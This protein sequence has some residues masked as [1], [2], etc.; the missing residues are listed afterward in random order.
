MKTPPAPPYLLPPEDAVTTEDWR[1]NDGSQIPER[2]EHWDPFTDIDLVRVVNVNIDAV[3]KACQLGDDS[4]LAVTASWVSTRT[5]LG[6]E[7]APVEIGTLDGAVRLPVA[8]S[9]PGVLAG[10]R[11]DIRTRLVLRYGGGKPS[12]ISPRRSGAVLW[13]QETRIELEGAAARFPV[14]PADFSG[15]PRLPDHGAWALE[16][17][18]EALEAP[19]LGTVRLLVNTGEQSLLDALRSGSTDV[20]ATLVRSFLTYDVARALVHG[21]LQNERFVGAPETFDVGSV[22][23]MLFELLSSCWPAMPVKALASRRLEDPSR[24]DAELQSYLGLIG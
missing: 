22:G 16:W 4:A 21:A 5:R 7:G 12:P 23:R 18:P 3:R 19:V 11:L 13:T 2:L 14:T 6:A 15:I 24:L 8:V 9:V 20:R 17:D 10:G 1:T